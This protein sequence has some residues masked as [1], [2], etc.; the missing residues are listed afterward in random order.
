MALKGKDKLHSVRLAKLTVNE[1]KQRK[2]T[3]H[4]VLTGRPV[5]K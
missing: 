2:P 5:E 3:L 1:N 4:I